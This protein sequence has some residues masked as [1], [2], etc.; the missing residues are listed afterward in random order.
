LISTP[1]FN[2]QRYSLIAIYAANELNALQKVEE[3]PPVKYSS[4]PSSL[5]N[6]ATNL[7]SLTKEISQVATE[8]KT[9]VQSNKQ[10][11]GFG[12]EELDTQMLT[13]NN[14]NNLK[15]STAVMMNIDT[16]GSSGDEPVVELAKPT[17]YLCPPSYLPL[18]S[19]TH[20]HSNT[21][22]LHRV[23]SAFTYTY[24]P[25]TSTDSKSTTNTAAELNS[26][27]EVLNNTVTYTPYRSSGTATAT[28]AASITTTASASSSPA[29]TS[30]VSMNMLPSPMSPS[31]RPEHS[32]V[33]ISMT[34]QMESVNSAASPLEAASASN[35]GNGSDTD[36]ESSEEVEHYL[37]SAAADNSS[38]AALLCSAHSELFTRSVD[39]CS[40]TDDN[41]DLDTLSSDYQRELAAKLAVAMEISHSQYQH[42][43]VNLFAVAQLRKERKLTLAPLADATLIQGISLNRSYSLLI[44]T[45][46]IDIDS[47]LTA[48][49]LTAMILT[50]YLQRSLVQKRLK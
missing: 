46:T 18:D 8:I 31:A 12:V 47:Y 19:I 9:E 2:P 48:M 41:N 13:E 28:A 3:A 44:V 5:L 38:L 26:S 36:T 22:T 35:H 4:S 16:A 15:E 7:P 42:S 10:S 25:S 43:T 30:S 17:S 14:N 49:I 32:P 20:A 45:H 27:T 6:T 23:K 1:G 29:S 39:D 37:K 11:N 21:L 24:S 40:N 34:P 50:V 33:N